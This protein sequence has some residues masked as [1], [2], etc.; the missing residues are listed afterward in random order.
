M[1]RRIPLLFNLVF[2]IPT[3]I[4]SIM[5]WV[6]YTDQ[7]DANLNRELTSERELFFLDRGNKV[8]GITHDD[9]SGLKGELYD[10]KTEKLIKEMPLYSNIHSQIVSAYQ[11]GRLIL[12]TNNA[13]DQ[14]EMNMIDSEGGVQELAQ[15]NLEF[16]GFVNNNVF[17]WRGKVIA[18]GKRGIK[19]PILQ[20]SIRGDYRRLI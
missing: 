11:N 7:L 15:G 8:L 19:L 10:V 14:L 18:M 1:K 9:D 13:E 16:S 17:S 5:V 4:L 2:F 20:R 12:V 6:D 3:I